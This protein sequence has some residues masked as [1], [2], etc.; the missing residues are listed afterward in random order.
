MNWLNWFDNLTFSATEKF[1]LSSPV[2]FKLACW[3]QL[4][5]DVIEPAAPVVK[6]AY[7]G[8]N[9]FNFEYYF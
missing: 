4:E 5:N 9:L 8:K 7:N 1:I 2:K 3:F 6:S